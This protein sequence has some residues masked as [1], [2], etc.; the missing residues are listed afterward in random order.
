MCTMKERIDQGVPFTPASRDAVDEWSW[1]IFELLN[2]WPVARQGRWSRWDPGYVVLEIDQ[3]EDETIEPI[4]LWTA[5]DELTVS[6]GFWE[7]H[8]PDPNG[9]FAEPADAVAEAKRLL[10]GWLDGR[11]RTAVYSN[12]WGWCGT[13]TVEPEVGGAPLEDGLKWLREAG[14]RPKRIELQGPRKADWL[15]YEVKGNRI[16]QVASWWD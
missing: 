5:D 9:H 1:S 2:A 7:D 15:C 10:D 8:L 16:E 12:D 4:V 3:L 11:L 6:F 14:F 13:T